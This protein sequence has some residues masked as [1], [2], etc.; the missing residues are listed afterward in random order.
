MPISNE[1]PSSIKYPKILAVEGEDEKNFFDRL[2]RNMRI[3]DIDIRIVGGKDQ[4]KS[5]LPALKNAPGFFS[6]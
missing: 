4:F 2:L 1:S 3:S 6:C 5:K